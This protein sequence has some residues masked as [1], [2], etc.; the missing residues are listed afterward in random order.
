MPDTI[1]SASQYTGK[2]AEIA[3]AVTELTAWSGDP[4]A[5]KYLDGMEGSK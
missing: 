5:V 1:L 2:K 3:S 4:K